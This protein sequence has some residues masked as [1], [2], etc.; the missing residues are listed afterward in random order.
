MIDI[1]YYFYAS[2]SL[3]DVIIVAI[4]IVNVTEQVTGACEVP[5]ILFH[6]PDG[7]LKLGSHRFKA[8][9]T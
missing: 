2:A 3:Y 8:R 7:K 5:K 9:A 4:I 6:F 1:N